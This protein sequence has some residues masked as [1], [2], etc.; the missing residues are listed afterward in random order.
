M[1]LKIFVLIIGLFVGIL[2]GSI[3][4]ELLNF[5]PKGLMGAVVGLIFGALA[6]NLASKS[7]SK[8]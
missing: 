1:I 7:K 5:E 4:A 2:V 6:W 8:K 3:G